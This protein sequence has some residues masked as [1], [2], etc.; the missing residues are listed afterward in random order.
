M[1]AVFT[2]VPVMNLL[3]ALT[4]GTHWGALGAADRLYVATALSGVT[5]V[6]SFHGPLR[7]T[8]RRRLVKR[9]R[10]DEASYLCFVVSPDLTPGVRSVP[11]VFPQAPGPVCL[12]GL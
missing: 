12:D 6:P 10:E 11:L 9:F 5:V 4:L 7:L 1:A 2:A 8:R 3:M